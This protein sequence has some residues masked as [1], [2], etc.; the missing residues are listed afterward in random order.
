VFYWWRIPEIMP[1]DEDHFVLKRSAKSS[2]TFSAELHLL[3]S[4]PGQ[5]GIKETE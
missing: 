3:Q 2:T 1:T 5:A 4:Q